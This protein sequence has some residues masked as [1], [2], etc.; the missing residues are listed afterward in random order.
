MRERS[1]QTGSGSL[2]A[3]LR[4]SIGASLP[5]WRELQEGFAPVDV[6]TGERMRRVPPDFDNARRA[7]I[8]IPIV[9]ESPEPRV[10]YTVRKGHLNDHAGQIS[11]PGGGVALSDGSLL[12][13]AL[14]EA[15]E[16]IDLPRAGVEVVGELEDMY[17]PPSNFLVRPFVGV[18]SP[19]TRLTLAPEE[20]ESVFSV[21]LNTLLAGETFQR[22]IL[23]RD[24]R[25]YHISVF[26]VRDGRESYEIWGATAAMTAS[27]LARLG[28]QAPL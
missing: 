28:W 7:A 26:A 22:R 23:S 8:L 25:D 13:T 17:I 10:V 21:S 11:F 9:A 12:D 16:E 2:A 1:R 24:G 15:E 4:E 19:E 3:R 18:I 6:Q 14:R 5:G 20:V 27:L